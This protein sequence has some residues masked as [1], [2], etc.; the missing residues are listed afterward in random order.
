MDNAEK[1]QLESIID[2]LCHMYDT[3][4]NEVYQKELKDLIKENEVNG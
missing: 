2:F 1:D 3:T 4:G